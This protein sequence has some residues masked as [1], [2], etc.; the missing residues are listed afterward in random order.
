[1]PRSKPIGL[2]G[3][4]TA[5]EHFAAIV[6]SSDDAILSKDP[7]GRITSWNPAAERMY[8]YSAEEAV[9]SHIS[10]LIPEHKAGEERQILDRILRG[11]RVDHY[12]TDR[13]RKD[14]RGIRVSL[15]VSPVRGTDGKVE[16]ASVIARDITRQHRS[17]ELASRLQEITT[18]LAQESTREPVIKVFLSQMVGALGAQAGAVGFVDGA[19]VVLSDTTGYS[20]E[21]LKGWARFPVDADLPMSE[22]I[23]EGYPLWMTAADDLV[24]RFPALAQADVRF[25]A[26]AILPLAVGEAPFGCVSLSFVESRDFDP[27]ERAFLLA[28]TQQAAY[29][30]NRAQMYEAERVAGDRQRFLA[31]ASELLASSLDPETALDQLASLA[32]LHVADWCGVE[33]V[34]ERGELHSVVV[35]HADEAKVELARQLRERYPVDPRSE[36]GVPNVIRTGNT[37]LYPEVP[38]EMLAEAA[39]DEEHLRHMRELGLRSAMIV[40]LRARGR[41]FGAITFVSSS[42][43]RRYGDADVELAEDLAR[44]AALAVDNAMLFRREHEAAVILQRSLLPDS[45]PT[46]HEG[47]EFDVRYRPAGPGIA[48][49]GDWYDIVLLDDGTVG[50]TIGDVAGRGLSAASVMGRIRPALR[51]YVLDGHS[52]AEAL[53]RLERL[54]KESPTPHMATLF[55]LHY[56][57]KSGSAIYVR[58][59]HPPALLRRADGEVQE[60][61]GP[62]TP[63]LGVLEDVEYREHRVEIPPGSLLLLYTDGLIE[64]RNSSMRHEL[65]R[66]KGLMGEAPR[67]A[68]GCLDWIEENL[69]ADAVPDDIAMVAMSIPG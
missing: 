10:I 53:E 30:L 34:D 45:V 61:S 9:G 17:L 5:S 44:R 62:G 28:A 27:E 33:M 39:R 7:D 37:E 43:D 51:A 25:Q 68:A 14:G 38:D 16:A 58:A 24:T 4:A 21:G 59:G 57:P 29:A 35:A 32:V 40:P 46:S 13:V 1:M 42:P 23:R 11:E 56:D 31:E 64:R 48:V 69:G 8:G 3:P 65:D 50:L 36:T 47:I 60:L 55:H 66:L 15:S 6:E 2:L 26:L 12:E 67:G 19:D 54:M 41:V 22:A 18:A 49:G 20:S 52:P 63:P